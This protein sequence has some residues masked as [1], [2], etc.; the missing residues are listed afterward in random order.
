MPEEPFRFA[1]PIQRYPDRLYAPQRRRWSCRAATPEDVR[2]WQAEARPVLRRMLGLDV[3]SEDAGDQVPRVAL[4][5][6]VEECSGF[7][8]RRGAIQTEPEVTIPFW[9]LVP[10]SPGPHPLAVTPH[11]HGKAGCDI[12]AGLPHDEP[13]RQRMIAEDRDVAVQSAR[14]G[15]VAIAPATRGLAAGGVTDLFGRFGQQNADCTSHFFHGLLAGRTSIGERVWDLGRLLDWALALPEVSPEHTLMM[16]NSG[17]GVATTYCAACDERVDVAVAS[18]S[19][20]TF[21]GRNGLIQHHHCN[22]VPG[23]YRFG[24]AWDVAGL[25]APRHFLAVHGRDDPIKA[26]DEVDRAVEGL[27]PIYAAAGVPERF[28]QRYGEGGH[29]FYA[30]LMWSFIESAMAS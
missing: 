13:T 18:C 19:Y 24:E 3:I 14:R 2:R 12:Y 22:A 25:I 15:F 28:E 20:A 29:R 21:V 26:T 1:E 30:D 16:G 5:D 17:G 11:G 4:V 6:E 8:R 27:R 9:L 7:T 10:T 23:I